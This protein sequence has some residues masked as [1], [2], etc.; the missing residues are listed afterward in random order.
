MTAGVA[1][2]TLST[3]AIRRLLEGGLARAAELDVRV[4]VAIMDSSA[5][6]VGFVSCE[7]APRLARV[8]AERKAFTS[9]NTEMSTL[10]WLQYVESIPESERRI[11]DS[12]PGY[13]GADGGFPLREDGILLGGIG[14]SG[15]D[16]A[17]DAD[18]ARAAMHAAGILET[19][20]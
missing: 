4:H 9:V 16:Q 13:V 7:G 19:E 5:D 15:A 17:R 3:D 8:T 1:R 14:V 20:P 11:I 10:R 2:G 18:I 12:I 6:L